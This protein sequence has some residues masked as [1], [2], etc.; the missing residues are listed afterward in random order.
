MP[1]TAHERARA[2]GPSSF[3]EGVND[4]L[5]EFEWDAVRDGE[6]EEASDDH[7]FRRLIK[8]LG[9]GSPVVYVPVKTIEVISE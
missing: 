8:Q 6:R 2:E 4:M 9:V 5:V 3:P 7:R 1:S